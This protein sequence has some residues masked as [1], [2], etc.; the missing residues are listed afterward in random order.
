MTGQA[1]KRVGMGI[2]AVCALAAAAAGTVG[3]ARVDAQG[4][5]GRSLLMTLMEFE[6]LHA[7]KTVLVVDVRSSG[8]FSAGHIPGAIHVPVRE[9]AIRTAGVKRAANGRLVVTYC[10]CPAEASSLIAARVLTDAGVAAKALVGG[11][12]RWVEFGGAIERGPHGQT[13]NARSA[14]LPLSPGT[15]HTRRLTRP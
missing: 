3:G 7:G 5:A 14:V 15:P 13:A 12:P 11:F 4:P 6:T 10:S 1:F 9:V 8:S 2:W